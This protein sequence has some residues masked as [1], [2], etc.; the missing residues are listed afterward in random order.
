M[1][2]TLQVGRFSVPENPVMRGV[3]GFGLLQSGNGYAMGNSVD[4]SNAAG[5]SPVTEDQN[6]QTQTIGPNGQLIWTGGNDDSPFTADYCNQIILGGTATDAQ[7]FQCSIRGYVGAAAV[8]AVPPALVPD[9]PTSVTIPRAIARIN[10]PRVAP[11]P[12]R[13]SQAA[14]QDDSSMPLCFLVLAGLFLLGSSR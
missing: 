12:R 11:A 10:A 7:K 6:N 8:Y 13:C 5:W 2:A 14:A 9:P 3:A 1:L 4:V